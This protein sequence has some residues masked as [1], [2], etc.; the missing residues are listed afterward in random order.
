MHFSS[1]GTT[2]ICTRCTHRMDL[3][4]SQGKQLQQASVPWPHALVSSALKSKL[5]TEESMSERVGTSE[6][7]EDLRRRR[8]T[9]RR[10][11]SYPAKMHGQNIPQVASNGLCDYTPSPGV[12]I[13]TL[14]VCDLSCHSQAALSSDPSLHLFSESLLLS[15]PHLSGISY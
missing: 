6:W 12:H 3:P 14:S 7:L 11:I 5:N 2:Q 13:S 9:R 8:K 10:S 1:T 15:E 4:S